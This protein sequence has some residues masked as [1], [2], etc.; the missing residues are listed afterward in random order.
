M[1][2]TPPVPPS[3]FYPIPYAE[4]VWSPSP[5]GVAA[6]PAA[7]PATT[8]LAVE[9]FEIPAQLPEANALLGTG[10]WDVL[11]VTDSRLVIKRIA[12]D[13]P[14]FDYVGPGYPVVERSDEVVPEDD[15]EADEE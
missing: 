15:A 2:F 13:P 11:H 12:P 6:A 9:A 5:G 1:S 4:G 3:T 8:V 7:A 14:P 10:R